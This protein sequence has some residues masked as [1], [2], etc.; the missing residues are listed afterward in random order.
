[1]SVWKLRVSEHVPLWSYVKSPHMAEFGIPNLADDRNLFG[2]C[3]FQ[4]SS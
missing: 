3:R 2:S 1:M 4:A